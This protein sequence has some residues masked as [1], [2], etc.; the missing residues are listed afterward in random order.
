MYHHSRTR[1]IQIPAGTR[2]GRLVTTGELVWHGQWFW[3][4]QCDCG[5]QKDVLGSALRAGTVSC[6]CRAREA[7]QLGPVVTHGATRHYRQTPEYAVW[8]Q[9]VL[10]CVKPSH[11]SYARYG[12]RGITV[13]DRWRHDYAAFLADMGPRPSVQ[14]SIDRLNNDGPYAPENCR[15][16]TAREQQNN[17]RNN[18]RLTC[19]GET[20]TLTEWSRAIGCSYERLRGL[21]RR[22]WSDEQ[23]IRLAV[24]RA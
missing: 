24:T 11:R 6:G 15:W 12:A 1:L 17:R 14:H 20:K 8:H 4:C 10:R 18:H 21:V 7:R 3:R 16:A 22:G 19:D 13:C 9:M 5:A 2:I 23:A